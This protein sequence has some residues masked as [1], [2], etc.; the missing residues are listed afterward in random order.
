MIR[1]RCVTHRKTATNFPRDSS[2]GNTGWRWGGVTE[3]TEVPVS[4]QYRHVTLSNEIGREREREREGEG[5][6]ERERW[7]ERGEGRG[8]C[9]HEV[10]H[11]GT[12]QDDQVDGRLQLNGEHVRRQLRVQNELGDEGELRRSDGLHQVAARRGVGRDHLLHAVALFLQ[13]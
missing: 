11:H 10:E 5:K 13:L 9:L 1:M 2:P 8:A 7:R 3:R 12:A 4:I 6:K